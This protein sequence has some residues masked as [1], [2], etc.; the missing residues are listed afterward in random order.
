MP[1]PWIGHSL[2]ID[3]EFEGIDVRKLEEAINQALQKGWDKLRVEV[4]KKWKA[5]ASTTLDSSEDAYLKGLT[6]TGSGMEIDVRLT[7]GLPVA[8]EQGSQRFDLKPGFLANHSSRVI[9]LHIKGKSKPKFVLLS[10]MQHPGWWHPGIQ[11]RAIHKQ[12]F[13]R[14]PQMVDNIFTPLVSRVKV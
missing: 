13:D 7:G 4:E 10:G 2:K 3:V 11:A 1:T 6:V 5:Q 12:I 9:P 8:V 14:T